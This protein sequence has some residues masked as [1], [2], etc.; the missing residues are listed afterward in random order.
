MIRIAITA[1]LMLLCACAAQAQVSTTEVNEYSDR[2]LAIDAGYSIE[3]LAE[4]RQVEHRE[5]VDRT[6]MNQIAAR[7]GKPDLPYGFAFLLQD[8]TGDNLDDLILLPKMAGLYP[9]EE[10]LGDPGAAVFV[11]IQ[12]ASG[13]KLAIEAGMMALGLRPGQVPGAID[14][15]FVQE[16]HIDEFFWDGNGFV[17]R[18]A[19]NADQQ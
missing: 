15:A 19:R 2:R 10:Y 17:K 9:P 8:L 1:T 5:F 12:T 16:R 13:W 14:I 7:Y 18:A 6:F 3:R 11:Y 4:H